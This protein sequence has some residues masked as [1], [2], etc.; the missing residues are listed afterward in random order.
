MHATGPWYRLRT[1][2][3]LGRSASRS[4]VS[5]RSI[6]SRAKRVTIGPTTGRTTYG[7]DR[8]RLTDSHSMSTPPG[9]AS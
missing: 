4:D 1:A 7:T 2:W 5:V 9:T 8:L 3:A 6:D